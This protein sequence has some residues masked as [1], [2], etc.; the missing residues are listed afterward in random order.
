MFSE[1]L[2]VFCLCVVTWMTCCVYRPSLQWKISSDMGTILFRLL[3]I[4]SQEDLLWHGYIPVSFTDH[5]FTGRS[6]LTWVHSWIS[7][8]K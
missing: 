2:F 1:L 8:T 6:P 5:Y 3:I 4:T 7:N